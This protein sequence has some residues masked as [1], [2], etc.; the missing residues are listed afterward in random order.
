MKVVLSS[1]NFRVEECEPTTLMAVGEHR[2]YVWHPRTGGFLGSISIHFDW[3]Q[4]AFE[5]AG[6]ILWSAGG[7]T[8]LAAFVR[9]INDQVEEDRANVEK[10]KANE[11]G[12]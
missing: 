7:L 10:E 9:S 1:Q 5:A 2:Y 8:D 4:Y 6:K 12:G 3:G 11:D